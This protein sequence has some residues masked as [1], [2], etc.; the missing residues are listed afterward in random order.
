MDPVFSSQLSWARPRGLNLNQKL[1]RR[2]VNGLSGMYATGAI[3]AGELLAS[4]PE[5]ALLKATGKS[6]RQEKE[7][8]WLEWIYRAAKEYQ[9]AESEYSGIFEGFEPLDNMKDYSSYFCSDDELTTL[10]EM[11]PILHRWI[12]DANRK[13][14]YVVTTLQ[15]H[16]PEID[17]DLILTVYLN[18]RSRGFNPQGVVP[19]L[20]QFN[21][22]DAFGQSSVTEN[23][24]ISFYSKKDYRADEQVFISYGTKDLYKHA[25]HYNYFDPSGVH[26]IEF[27]RKSIQSA[28]GE[29]G[30]KLYTHLKKFFKIEK[31]N[32][33]GQNVFLVN[34]PTVMLS[35]HGLSEGLVKLLKEACRTRLP[36][37]ASEQELMQ[38]AAHYFVYL[39]EQQLRTNRVETIPAS[40][41]TARLARFH[42]LLI[43]EKQILLLHRKKTLG[44]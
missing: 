19:V 41:I 22:S 20:D 28:D 12:L 18:L 13:A 10:K 3:A 24:R 26:F 33:N 37:T 35:E 32:N 34:D 42:E 25:I 29:I 7:S 27:G 43:K 1:E 31:L 36:N 38:H 30:A 17:R 39:I 15:K 5:D 8:N 21:H 9:K 6:F 23:G 40:K 2:S 14:N 4:F 11:S 16:D 44:G